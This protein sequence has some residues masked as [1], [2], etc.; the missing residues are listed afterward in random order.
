MQCIIISIGREVIKDDVLPL[1]QPI[2]TKSGKVI[3]ELPIPKGTRLLM[4]M[5]G[6]HMW[7]LR[8]FQDI[9]HELMYIAGTKK[10]GETMSTSSN[11]RG[12]SIARTRWDCLRTCMSTGL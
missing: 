3:N 6:Y 9:C 4:S 5:H 10:S 8:R 11:P 2:V 12:G 7:V 1:S